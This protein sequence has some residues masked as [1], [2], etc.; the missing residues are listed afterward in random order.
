MHAG[1]AISGMFGG[2]SSQAEQQADPLLQSQANDQQL[3][4]SCDYD[5]K[6]LTK[7]LDENKGEY[8]MSICN[9]Y[10]EQLVS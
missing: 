10:L 6:A 4:R 9:Y 8:S 1:H 2:G 3:A 5:A 7:C